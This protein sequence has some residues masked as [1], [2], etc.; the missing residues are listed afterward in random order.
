MAE[1]EQGTQP[2]GQA[3]KGPHGADAAE[4]DQAALRALADVYITDYAAA[5]LP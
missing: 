3:E 4:P 5:P 1:D 2:E